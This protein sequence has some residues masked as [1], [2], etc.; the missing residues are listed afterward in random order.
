MTAQS[1]KFTKGFR[2]QPGPH[3]SFTRGRIQEEALRKTGIDA[4]FAK[5]L[6]DGFQGATRIH[7]VTG[8]NSLLLKSSI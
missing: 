4:I 6:F 5:A 7:L 3:F 1:S 2:I 8:K